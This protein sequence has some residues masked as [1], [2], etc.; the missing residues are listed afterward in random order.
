MAV[1]RSR[2]R[3]LRS[4]AAALV[5]ALPA[6]AVAADA[7]APAEEKRE[8]P[9][10]ELDKL[11]ELPGTREYSVESRGGAT[12]GEW[13]SRFRSVREDLAAERKAL[14]E[15]EAELDEVAGSTD[16]WQVGPAIPGGGSTSGAEA[17]LDYRLRQKIER[18]RE[19]VERL[20]RKLRELEVEANLAGVPDAWREPPSEPGAGGAEGSR[21]GG[22]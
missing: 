19:E 16:A 4:A 17:P 15:A 21:S 22:S 14:A 6:P 13:R 9:R 20:E 18:H 8:S 7:G 3:G 11:L 5:L 12:P 1:T 10:V 2:A